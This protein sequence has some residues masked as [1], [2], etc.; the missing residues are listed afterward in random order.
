MSIWQ[1][2]NN[3]QHYIGENL[4]KSLYPQSSQP[5][6]MYGSS[7]KHKTPVDGFPKLRFILSALNTGTYKWEKFFL[8]LSK[9]LTSNQFTLKDSLEQDAGL[10][11]ASLDVDSLFTNVP[12]EETIHIL[13]NELFK[14]NSSIHGLN[15]KQIIEMLSLTTK[16]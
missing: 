5:G 2:Y 16:E 11:V 15:K 8:P 10:F 14:S 7:K 3:N 6:I 9:H 1:F 12:L 13:V 4:Y